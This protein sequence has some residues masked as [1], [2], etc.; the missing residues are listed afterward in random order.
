M[1]SF[2]CTHTATATNGERLFAVEAHSDDHYA[3]ATGAMP[4]SELRAVVE[5]LGVNGLG[6]EAYD[7]IVTALE[8]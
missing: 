3:I 8:E 6:R 1:S 7:T 5:V 4:E 2:T